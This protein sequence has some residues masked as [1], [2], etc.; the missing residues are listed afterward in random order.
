MYFSRQKP[1]KNMPRREWKEVDWFSASLRGLLV[2]LLCSWSWQYDGGNGMQ[3]NCFA[4]AHKLM[5]LSITNREL[6][7][8][9]GMFG[10][11]VWIL[12]KCI[13]DCLTAF[14]VRDHN[15][16]LANPLTSAQVTI[17]ADCHDKEAARSSRAR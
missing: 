2:P 11:R 12:C 10:I 15:I 3:L 17:Q 1:S 5:P 4:A 6:D 8:W 7:F 9:G 14:L 13:R 16:S